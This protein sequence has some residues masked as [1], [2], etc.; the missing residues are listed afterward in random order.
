MTFQFL[1]ILTHTYYIFFYY[2]HTSG[3]KSGTTFW[4]WYVSLWWLMTLSIFYILVVYL[5]R[6]AYLD[7]LSI[8]STGLSFYIE[9]FI[10]S[11]H[12]TLTRYTI[13]KKILQFCR[14]SFHIFYIVLWSTN[15]FTYFTF[16]ATPVA[17]GSSSARDWIWVTAATYT[18]A[19]A[20]LDPLTQWTMLGVKPMPPQ[21]LEL[22]Q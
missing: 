12:M 1:H 15:F 4:V 6:N 7:L 14:L 22:L 11:R 8:F 2:N 16:M 19:A 17:Y 5:W 21:W 13:C 3:C 20:M 10:Y 18:A 9:F